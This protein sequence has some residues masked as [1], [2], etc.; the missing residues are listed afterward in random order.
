MFLIFLFDCITVASSIGLCKHQDLGL[1]S[2]SDNYDKSYPPDP[3]PMY[4]NQTIT[5]FDIVEFD[6]DARTVT[7]FM[8]IYLFWN[9]T[10]ITKKFNSSEI[11]DPWVYIDSETAEDLYFPTMKYRNVES[12]EVQKQCSPSS[13]SNYYWFKYP[14]HIEFIETIKITIYC[15]F[16]FS[17]YPFDHHQ[18]NFTFGA[19]YSSAGNLVLGPTV[20]LFD[21][22]K[23]SLKQKSGINVQ[24]SRLT[25]DIML[26]GLEPFYLASYGLNYSFAGF[27]IHFSRNSLGLLPGSFYVPTA[28][29][30]VLATFS[31]HINPDVV[32]LVT[33]Q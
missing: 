8:Q 26:K 27:N 33:E 22:S 15:T 7:L 17:S 2:L 6:Q 11:T 4:L 13:T 29:L 3:R 9:D 25:F 14:H 20:I 23:T 10:R 30:S 32:S 12:I 16:E 31:F 28:I 18:C 1:C 21:E 19:D 24:S 5:L